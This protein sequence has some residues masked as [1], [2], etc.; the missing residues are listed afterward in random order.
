[1]TSCGEKDKGRLGEY[2]AMR[3]KPQDIEFRQIPLVENAIYRKVEAFMAI[4]SNV[5]AFVTVLY[6]TWAIIEK[7]V[8]YE[9]LGGI[10]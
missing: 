5:E 6:C 9:P 10:C 8:I 7:F 2:Q 3:G 4:L 1:M